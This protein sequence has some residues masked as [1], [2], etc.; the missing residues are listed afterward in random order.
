VPG[1]AGTGGAPVL[2]LPG[3]CIYRERDAGRE[4]TQFVPER[5]FGVQHCGEIHHGLELAADL[6]DAG[7]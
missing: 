1:P 6:L 7:Q 3:H 2:E 4:L 5:I